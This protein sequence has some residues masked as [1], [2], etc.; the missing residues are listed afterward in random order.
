MPV[1]NNVCFVC[2]CSVAVVSRFKMTITSIFCYISTT[3]DFLLL[4]VTFKVNFNWEQ[5]KNI[6]INQKKQLE[7]STLCI[8]FGE[9]SKAF[10]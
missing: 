4:S 3:L 10:T 9:L 5:Q 6:Q 7:A 1:S 8:S 2:R